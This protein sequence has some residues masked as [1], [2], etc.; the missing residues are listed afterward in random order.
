MKRTLSFA[1]TEN[2]VQLT[3]AP[4][5]L[6]TVSALPFWEK[7]ALPLATTG[8]VGSANTG[9]N[10]KHPRKAT[11]TARTTSRTARP[12]LIL[13]LHFSTRHPHDRHGVCRDQYLHWVRAE[14]C[15]QPSYCRGSMVEQCRIGNISMDAGP[16]KVERVVSPLY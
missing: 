8:K 10:G 16:S 12:P 11:A 15:G 14:N 9:E 6:V 3:M 4:L 5:P 1:P 2:V 7:L 13:Q